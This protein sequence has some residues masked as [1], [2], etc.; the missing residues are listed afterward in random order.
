MRAPIRLSEMPAERPRWADM[1]RMSKEDE[2][3][4]H[5]CMLS[6]CEWGRLPTARLLLAP[7]DL[8]IGSGW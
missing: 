1:T 6:L 8:R 4:A 5:A 2:S 3:Y 7:L